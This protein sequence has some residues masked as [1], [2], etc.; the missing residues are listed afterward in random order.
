MKYFLICPILLI[1]ALLSGVNGQ[2]TIPP[3][4]HYSIGDGLPQMQ[5][6]SLLSDSRGYLW[7]GTKGGVCRYNG[8]DFEQ[9]VNTDSLPGEAVFSITEAPDGKIWMRTSTGLADFDGKKLTS[10][11]DVDGKYAWIASTPD[12]RTWY[13]GENDTDGYYY[14]YFENGV[15][16]T[17]TRIPLN[18]DNTPLGWAVCYDDNSL[19]L[20]TKTDIYNVTNNG[21]NSLFYI[22]D[23]VAPVQT[24]DHSVCFAIIKDTANFTILKYSKGKF[25][26]VAKVMNGSFSGGNLLKD[27]VS[28]SKKSGSGCMIVKVYSDH[29]IIDDYHDV[30]YNA[31][32][33]DG[34]Q[35]LWIGAEDGLYRMLNRGFET[36][37]KDVLPQIWNIAEDRKGNMLFGSYH[38]GLKLFN[39]KS[40]E[41][42]D[43]L[44][45]LNKGPG[46]YFKAAADEQGTV[47][48][49]MG[50]GIFAWH[51]PDWEVFGTNAALTVFYDDKHKQILGG[52][53]RKVKVYN[54]SHE[55]VRTI[56]QSRGLE[57]RNF[58]TT[59]GKDIDGFF[60][61]GG[62]S[63]LTR[64]NWDQ[65]SLVNY[66]RR[67]KRLPADGAI[68]VYNDYKGTTWFGTTDGLC[69]Y[70][71]SGDSISM[72]GQNLMQG[73]VSLVTSADST[74]LIVG[75]PAGL[76]FMD[77]QE[78]Y[79][80]GA[81]N[82]R[83]FNQSN[84]FMGVEPGQDGAFKDSKGNIW[85]TSA[86]E[87]TRINPEKIS[88]G[89]SRLNVRFSSCNG[90]ILG[91][92]DTV[93]NLPVNTQS[94]II[95]FDAICFSRPNPV[96]YSWKTDKEGSEWSP[97][98]KADYAVLTDLPH[99]KTVVKLRAM[100]PG[101]PDVDYAQA[102][103]SIKTNIWIYKREWFFPALFGLF[104]FASIISLVFLYRARI[105]IIDTIRQA[106]VVQVRALQAQ[107]NPHFIFNV[108][109]ALQSMILTLNLD[110]ANTYLIKLAKLIRGYLDASGPAK[111]LS[112]NKPDGG[113]ISLSHEIELLVNY[114]DFQQ[115]V[116]PDG[117]DAIWEI[118]PTID[119]ETMYIPPMLIQPFVENAIRHGLMLKNSRGILGITITPHAKNGIQVVVSD[120]GAGIEKAAKIIRT[121]PFRHISKGRDLTFSRVQ[122]LNELGYDIRITT[123]SSDNGTV[124]TINIRKK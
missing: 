80:S 121:S 99:G 56:D 63:G 122:L 52:F 101:L 60:W 35:A 59:I 95:N 31:H 54:R 86:T 65:D 114:I 20:Y 88:W 124:V 57:I 67:N 46:F 81:I 34:N 105:R 96:Q 108:L 109:A 32:A 70:F 93:V 66:N 22:R 37:K 16:H 78:Y 23:S 113:E 112:Y 42:V 62:F 110:E 50:S 10:F 12:G 18:E 72:V 53:H 73:M 2:F 102:S 9:P 39:G 4:R 123:E 91:F 83:L 100:V 8:K 111:N 119:L 85:V 24:S 106:K 44:D 36:F 117:F 107:M 94:T 38:F 79:R 103:I 87:V 43:L 118:D 77:L 26:E 41:Q 116:I 89:N 7:I 28:F 76:Y 69:R 120:N 104:A 21:G 68:S 74:W 115:L 84:G 49:P 1:H 98:Q 45:Y 75:Q 55:L 48:L 61:F 30:Q 97:W 13:A 29:F 92:H 5:V 25:N 19:I 64:Y 33:Y 40:I 11:H 27:P 51:N 58:V 47:Y 3:Y 90:E 14:G 15:Y 6:M 17:T 71:N 82:L